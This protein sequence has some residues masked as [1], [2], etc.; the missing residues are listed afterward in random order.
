MSR[1]KIE[2]YTKY[3]KGVK[4]QNSRKSTKKKN[5]MDSN[6]NLPVIR[7]NLKEKSMG[8]WH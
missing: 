2:R 3:T 1:K 4:R 5:E 8:K 7:I 6:I